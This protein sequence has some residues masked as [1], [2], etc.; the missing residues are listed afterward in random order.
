M[1]V[2][3][4]EIKKRLDP[5]EVLR[6]IGYPK[7]APKTSGGEIRD[8]CPVHQGDGPNLAIGAN[9]EWYCHSHGCKG[10]NLIS[11]YQ[12]SR[13]IDFFTAV[14]E[15]A[16]HFGIP[17]REDKNIESDESLQKQSHDDDSM[18][19]KLD[20]SKMIAAETWMKMAVVGQ[21]PYFER[22][23]IIAP[24]GIRYG[25]DVY[26]NWSA[27]I[28]FYTANPRT[29]Q[30]L[31]YINDSGKYFLKGTTASGA[32]FSI[33]SISVPIAYFCEGLATACSIWESEN[34]TITTISCG[35]SHNIAKVIGAI[36]E[37]H[38]NMHAIVC[39]DDD[40]TAD[41]TIK[42]VA[43]LG[44]GGISFRKPDFAAF[45]RQKDEKGKFLDKDFNDLHQLAGP[46]AVQTQLQREW[47]R[48][49][50]E[51]N[52]PADK[53]DLRFISEISPNYF[54]IQ[55]PEKPRLLSF[56]D[57][58]GH[59][60]PFMHKGITA[61]LVGAGGPGK[62]KDGD[63]HMQDKRAADEAPGEKNKGNIQQDQKVRKV[64]IAK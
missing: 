12:H 17:V 3:L 47:K 16:D 27:V 20:A 11:L 28:P 10:G 6:L 24:L 13:K 29:I 44:V 55:P 33:G 45:E 34:K 50:Q 35:S 30:T 19:A 2:N 18:D 1:I 14:H 9:G 58:S 54:V 51:K 42:A 43:A 36:K 63:Q 32:F 62:E 57:D 38:P 40:H 60:V 41:A 21:H 48:P 15:L 31:Q 25:N 22:K 46:E 64:M 23:G 53:M 5:F 7:S 61:M 37:Q 8:V 52:E 49:A 26:G 39:L 59:R 56:L 4:D